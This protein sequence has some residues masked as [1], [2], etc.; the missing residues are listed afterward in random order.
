VSILF[1]VT[2]RRLQHRFVRKRPIWWTTFWVYLGLLAVSSV[3][4]SRGLLTVSRLQVERSRL[5]REISSLRRDV[6]DLQKRV[7]DFRNDPRELEKYAREE[8][9]LVGDDEIQYLFQ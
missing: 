4:S 6:A 3:F 5:D 7:R 9:R 8:L 2:L 1:K